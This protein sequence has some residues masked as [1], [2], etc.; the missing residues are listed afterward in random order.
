M[1][2]T[3]FSTA[4]VVVVFYVYNGDEKQNIVM[5]SKMKEYDHKHWIIVKY[6][7]SVHSTIKNDS[8]V[9][10]SRYTSNPT[11]FILIV[12]VGNSDSNS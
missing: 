9:V 8:K 10:Q 11:L 1:T 3:C 4:S 5:Q 7:L 2:I 12:V 6:Y